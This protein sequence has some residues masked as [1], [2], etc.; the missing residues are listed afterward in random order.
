M[1]LVREPEEITFAVSDVT[2]AETL[3][4]TVKTQQAAAELLGVE[5]VEACCDYFDDCVAGIRSHPLIT[6]ARLAH[7]QHRPLVLSPDMVWLT[8]LQS[9]SDHLEANWEAMKSRI[10]DST[11]SRLPLVV[12]TAEFPFGSPEAPWFELIASGTN[13]LRAN[14]TEEVA[15]LFGLSF[16]TTQP[17][18]RTAM[19]LA[20]LSGL[21]QY[22]SFLDGFRICGIPSITLEGTTDDWKRILAAVDVLESFELEWWTSHLRPICEEFVRAAE[23]NPNL[24]HWKTIATAHPNECS[25][26]D[27]VTGWIGILCAYQN[28]RLGFRRNGRLEGMELG[29]RLG[30]FPLGISDV[31]MHSQRASVVHLIGGFLGVGQDADSKAL[32]PKVGWAVRR[33][34]GFES[35]LHRVSGLS[36]CEG[37]P[38][39]RG[40]DPAAAS[41]G[42]V[43]VRVTSQQLQYFYSRYSKLVVRGDRGAK[44][45]TFLP[46]EQ[47]TDVWEREL[48]SFL[49][50][51]LSDLDRRN[52]LPDLWQQIRGR[53][54]FALFALLPDRRGLGF[55]TVMSADGEDLWESPA[56]FLT[57]P[58]SREVVLLS[59]NFADVLQWVIDANDEFLDQAPTFKPLG[60]VSV[61]DEEEMR[62]LLR[63][64][65]RVD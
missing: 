48:P 6:A 12:S 3:L 13:Q 46:A 47:I 27:Y 50:T 22:A 11:Y 58:Q 59:N 16:S 55:R 52:A 14:V 45:C 54:Q 44:V 18:Q 61:Y 5:S 19:D 29:P 53:F 40:F 33:E 56:F 7:D 4:P 36:R 37:V 43:L 62:G 17:V 60:I 34:T 49:P 63:P 41:R 35:L 9:F 8:I 38:Q 26:D 21:S 28:R 64:L 1:T 10:V 23:G 39:T 15:A 24:E 20:F 42:N 25:G 57:I 31:E 51:A 65:G 32:R 2:L 30:E